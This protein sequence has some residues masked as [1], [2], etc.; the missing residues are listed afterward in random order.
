MA[1]SRL[2]MRFQSSGHS[3]AALRALSYGSPSAKLKD[4]TNGIDFYRT[5]AALEEKFEEK[6]EEL[7]RILQELTRQ[8]FRPDNL[9]ISYTASRE[10][11]KGLEEMIRSLKES[12]FT[13]PVEEGTC[14][15]HCE[16]KNEGFKTAFQGPVCGPHRQLYRPGS[17]VYRRPPDP[18][19]DLKLR[20]P[21]AEYPGKRRALTVCMSSFNRVGEGY[22]VSY[23]DPH[24]KRTMDVYEGVTEYLKNF[25]VSERDMTK[26]IIGTMSNIDHPMTPCAKGERSMN[27]YMNK[28][29]PE[30][31]REERRQILEAGQEDIRALAK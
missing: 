30:M 13:D 8:L 24:L 7:I 25:T 3:T 28:V 17:R 2:L 19:G 1:K 22:L 5:V 21:V 29:S 27:L 9:M 15:L 16:K 20:L 12:L 14:V 6:K 18:E 10:G 23:R 26:Y 11:L 4:L 31:I